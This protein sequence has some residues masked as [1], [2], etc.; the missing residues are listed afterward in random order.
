VSL[1]DLKKAMVARG[2]CAS[3]ARWSKMDGGRTNS[4]WKVGVG[5]SAII[6]KVFASP[7]DNPLYPNQA[8]SEEAALKSLD[9]S[10]LAPDFLTSFQSEAGDVLVYRHLEGGPWSGD[11]APVAKLLAQ[12]HAAP[13]YSGLR[14]MASG[15][16]AL[17]AQVHE[18][19]ADCRGVSRVSLDVD[20]PFVPSID[21]VRL[22]HTDV[23]ANNIV[24]T[25]H[26]LRLI[27]WQCPAQGDPCEDLASFLSP[28]MQ[29]LYGDGALSPAQV[30]A[31]L[32]AYPD[33]EIVARY[34]RLAPLFHL[35]IAAYCLWKAERGGSP[36]Y[37]EA[38]KCEVS[39]I[40]QTDRQEQHTG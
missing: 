22:I 40:D 14:T 4:V 36:D 35:R 34:K 23:V 30:E 13:T 24:V 19:C 2:L 12:V 28:A 16:E 9:Q 29:Y 32:S 39:A 27:D 15:S 20:A 21:K 6:C 18:I 33:Q 1:T 7:S 5:Q 25:P 17:R 38:M 10:G 8:S 3:G 37:A 31:F 11:A 26:G